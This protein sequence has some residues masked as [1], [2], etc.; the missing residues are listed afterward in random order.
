M[1][2]IEFFYWFCVGNADYLLRPVEFMWIMLLLKSCKSMTVLKKFQSQCSGK[3]G[4]GIVVCVNPGGS[5]K[6][7]HNT[8]KE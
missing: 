3:K 2:K 4:M 1:Q 8:D 6:C 5:G 7:G